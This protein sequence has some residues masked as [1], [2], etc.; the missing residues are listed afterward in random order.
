MAELMA[1]TVPVS[2]APPDR[3]F[4]ASPVLGESTWAALHEAQAWVV[5][6]DT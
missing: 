3:A 6:T 1:K 2:V 4:E 5:T